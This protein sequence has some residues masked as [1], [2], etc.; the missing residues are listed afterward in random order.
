MSTKKG[1][2]QRKARLNNRLNLMFLKI[3]IL[4]IANND[5]CKKKRTLIKT[6]TLLFTLP[7]DE[8]ISFPH[9]KSLPS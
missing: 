2:I 5:P 4:E 8:E 1:E 6:T 7:K 9:S 3:S